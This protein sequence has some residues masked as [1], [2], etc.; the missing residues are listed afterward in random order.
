MPFKVELAKLGKKQIDLL[1]EVRK[2]GYPNLYETQLSVYLSGRD[3]SPQGWMN[4]EKLKRKLPNG[5]SEEK[6]ELALKYL[7]YYRRA[8][9][10]MQSLNAYDPSLPEII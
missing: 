1:A 10:Y 4:K 2:R 5:Q 9:D 3:R 8:A 6:N 7:D